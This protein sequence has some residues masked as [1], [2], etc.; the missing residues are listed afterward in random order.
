MNILRIGFLRNLAIGGNEAQDLGP[1][2]ASIGIT[3]TFDQRGITAI[4]LQGYSPFGRAN[5]D[6]GNR[7]NTWQLDEEFTYTEGRHR[8]AFGAGLR[9]RRGWHG[10][11]NGMAHG[12]LSFQPA[13][14]AQLTSNPQGQVVPMANTGDS[15][16]D[17]LLGVPVNGTLLGFPPVEYRG[18]QFAPF[19]QDSWK[20]SSN[21]TLNYGISWFLDTPPES[22]GWA[23]NLIHGFDT[24]SGLLTFA[25]LGQMSDQAVATD[26]NNFAPR[27]GVAW[28]PGFLRDTVIRA[29]AGVYY[30]TFQWFWAPYPLIGSPVG[31]GSSFSNALSNPQPAYM[32]GLNIFPPAPSGALTESYAANVPAGI[33]A[34]ALDPDFRIGYVSQWNFSI[35]RSVTRDD[36]IEMD[37]LGSSGHRL[38]NVSDISQ[39]R[40]TANLFCGAKTWP[41]YGAMLWA[42]S[43]GNSSYQALIAKY[44]HRESYGLNLRFE[45]GLAKAIDRH[46]AI[47]CRGQQSVIELSSLF[48]GA[49]DVRCSAPSG[50]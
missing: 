21:L 49:C 10:N 15:F 26:R 14:T 44:E 8:F 2:L 19:F 34:T 29:G 42:D 36:S 43:G 37:Y 7:D 25:A 6:V 12:S 47:Q 5:G 32:M 48:E 11:G 33:V 18:M 3:N 1:I 28:K 27:L 20:L 17:F 23:R 31:V 30:S 41:R 22:Q 16:A 24:R 13:F 46:L 40:P 50:R 35:Q 4:N 9:Y 39:C 45:Y 38:P